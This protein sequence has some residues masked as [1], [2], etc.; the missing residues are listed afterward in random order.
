M[1]FEFGSIANFEALRA[2]EED[3]V[4]RSLIRGTGAAAKIRGLGNATV[5]VRLV[6][7]S[8]VRLKAVLSR[9]AQ[10]LIDLACSFNQQ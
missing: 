8:Y 2:Q 9:R 5:V 7:V 1:P 3:I 10:A 4:A 6:E